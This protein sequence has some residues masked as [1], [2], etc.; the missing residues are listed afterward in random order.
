MKVLIVLSFILAGC[1]QAPVKIPE[2]GGIYP[3]GKYQHDV[4]IKILT[5]PRTMTMRGVVSYTADSL[6][7]IGLSSFGTTVFRIDENLKTG[8]ISK[9]FY[10]DIIRKNEDKFME[11]Y[12]IIRELVTAPK[13]ATD[14]T[15]GETHFVLSDP[16][17]NG[18]YCTVH[19]EHPQFVLDIDVTDYDF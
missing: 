14:F 13:G 3:Y 2:G 17:E 12:R 18:I 7:V 11:F 6:K 4:K 19:V 9:E 16:D 5:P 1:T 10:M 15:R 8:E